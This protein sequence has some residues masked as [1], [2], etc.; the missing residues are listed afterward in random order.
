MNVLRQI[1]ALTIKEI[2]VLWHD[3]EALALLF[4]MPVFFILVMS[5]ALQ[6]VFE[7]GS[8]KRP[9][10]IL[11]INEDKGGEAKKII[12]T[13]G[14]MEGIKIIDSLNDRPLT[15]RVAAD[16]I[17]SG[18]FFAALHFRRQFSERI[19]SDIP[20]VD[21][22]SPALSMIVDP[23]INIQLISSIKGTIQGIIERHMFLYR[24]T[25][26]IDQGVDRIGE[27][28][29]AAMIYALD[30]LKSQLKGAF[31]DLSIENLDREL[32]SIPIIPLRVTEA[33]RRPTSTEQN[34]PAYT[35]FGVFFIVLTLASS[36]IK[37]KNDG[38]FQRVLTAP[39]S[40]AALV[41]GKLLP[42]YIVNLIQIV[43]MFTVGVLFFDLPL[44]NLPALILVSLA[45]AASANGLGL[46]VAT[47][48]KTEAQV[49]GLSVMLAI[50]LSAMGGIMVPVFVMP[51]FMKKL[52]QFTPHAWALTGYHD[53]IIRGLGLSDVMTEIGVLAGFS[54]LFFIIALWRLRF[55]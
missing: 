54:G 13:L 21:D 6:G 3:R 31:S 1:L 34:V 47:I 14:K 10:E 9:I 51:G 27:N 49:N 5:L 15:Y 30:S 12:F 44:G 42:Y 36:F 20:G 55:D 4:L 32:L 38:T 41:M 7:S 33:S 39:L 52:A 19:Q 25:R 45:L 8:R 53:V 35:I 16:H 18:K 28:G 29:N 37:E 40:K 24:L 17:N 50:T 2:R 11:A 43:L 23:T 46:L 22:E 26:L 48:G